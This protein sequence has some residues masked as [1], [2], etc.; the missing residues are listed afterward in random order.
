MFS[1]FKLD[2]YNLIVM[3]GPGSHAFTFG[4]GVSLVVDC[5]DQ[6]EVDHFWNNLTANGGQ[7]SMCAW[8]KDGFGVWWQI[9]PTALGKMLNDPD[10]EKANRVMQAMLKMKKI[11]IADL[12]KAAEAEMVK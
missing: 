12:E 3:D 2:N 1:E 9:V 8:L 7:E 11:V 10:R 6:D 4:E 5:K